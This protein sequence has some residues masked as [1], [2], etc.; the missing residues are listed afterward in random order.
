[1]H[2]WQLH[3]IIVFCSFRPGEE[4]RQVYDKSFLVEKFF[5]LMYV[6]FQVWVLYRLKILQDGSIKRRWKRNDRDKRI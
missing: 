5:L 6:L 1:M 2:G 4:L 3:K